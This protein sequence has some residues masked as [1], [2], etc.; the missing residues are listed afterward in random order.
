MP[1]P[2][3]ILIF[4]RY[5]VPGRVK[6]RLIPALGPETAA[7]LH[8]HMTEHVVDMARGL[9]ESGDA[10]VHVC[11]TGA[12]LKKFRSWLGLDLKYVPQA[13]DDLG[14]R[15]HHG[16]ELVF[17]T[18]PGPVVVLGSDL[19][20]L[21]RAILAQ[22]LNVLETSDLVIGPAEDGGYCLIGMHSPHTELFK[23]MDWGSSYVSAQATDAARRLG[24]RT[25]VLPALRDV[26]RPEDLDVLRH[27]PRFEDVFTGR[28]KISII[29]PCL[30]EAGTLPR[31]LKRISKNAGQDENLE[32]IVVDGGSRDNTR[33]VAARSGAL[34]LQTQAGRAVQQNVG[35]VRALGRLLLFLHA[36]TLLPHG[37]ARCIRNALDD[38]AVTAGAFR[39]R[40]DSPRPAMRL[41]EGATNIRS[42]IFRTPYG[43]QGLFLERRVFQELGGFAPL[44]IM[45]DFELVRRLRKRGRI[46]TL[47]ET[48]LTSARRWHTLGLIRTTLVNQLMVLGFACGV[49]VH[50]LARLYRCGKKR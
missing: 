17:Q 41:I 27:D 37:F 7:R 46:V 19:P 39:L 25:A 30:N 29:I 21:D 12:P 18:G 33:S 1:R 44:P 36:D 23:N 5:P 49:P 3:R 2:V 32:V 38:P 42:A 20:G 35:A 22:A 40:T 47:P 31:T 15:M 10:S 50:V 13:G 4:T 28:C 8:R 34:V 16:V 24:L 11:F 26:D 6:T 43:D 9:A 45:E 14:Q 48:V